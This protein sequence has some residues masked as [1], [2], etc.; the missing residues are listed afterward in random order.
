MILFTISL[1][2]LLL[3]LIYVLIKGVSFILAFG[4][5]IICVLLVWII[6]KHLIKKRD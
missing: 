6:I 5:I 3:S 1:C 2:G 4:D